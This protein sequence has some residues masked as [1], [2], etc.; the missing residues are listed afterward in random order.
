ML[1]TKILK[2]KAFFSASPPTPPFSPNFLHIS[3]VLTPWILQ[4]IQITAFVMPSQSICP[5]DTS[6][7]FHVK[8]YSLKRDLVL[9]RQLSQWKHFPYTWKPDFGFPKP[10]WGPGMVIRDC[11]TRNTQERNRWICG[12]RWLARLVKLMSSGFIGGPC[13]NNVGLD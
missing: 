1:S 6:C 9:R 2:W 12:T 13:F 10:T 4:C 11:N 5:K 8:G 3:S 7:F